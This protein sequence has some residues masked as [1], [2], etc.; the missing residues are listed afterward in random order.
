MARAASSYRANKISHRR[1]ERLAHRAHVR[2]LPGASLVD[3]RHRD[4]GAREVCQPPYDMKGPEGR[5]VKKANGEA[6]RLVWRRAE[7]RTK[8][9][10]YR[11]AETAKIQAILYPQRAESA[12][13]RKNRLARE[14]RSSQK[15]LQD[16]AAAVA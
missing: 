12:R 2:L 9:K 11:E 14:R 1:G 15:A 16:K 6:F 13:D 4:L 7:H 3:P 5:I 10:S 8:G